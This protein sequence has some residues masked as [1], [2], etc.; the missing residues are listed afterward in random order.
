MS[1]WVDLH[2]HS[3]RSDGTETP[4][5][6]VARA[7]ATGAAA[8]ALTD[9]DTVDG[10]LAAQQAAAQHGMAFLPGVEISACFDGRELHIVGLGID[11]EAP[12]LTQLL[13]QLSQMRCNR[14]DTII[15]RLQDNGVLDETPAACSKNT[16]GGMGRMHVAVA[17]HEMGKAKTVQHAFDKYLNRGCIAHVPKQLPEAA[18]AVAAIHAANG[19]AFM[20][21]PGLGRWMLKQMDRL[22]TLP[23]DGLEAWHPSHTPSITNEILEVALSHQLLISGGSDCHGNIKGEGTSLGRIRTPIIHFRQIVDALHN[24]LKT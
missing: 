11:T 21:H 24:A 7:A 23:F 18:Q 10:V 17:L 5:E 20:A 16:R 3:S 9:H 4:E 6:L 8:I 13:E 19:L 1:A 15:R 22:L 14:M 12:A 2:L